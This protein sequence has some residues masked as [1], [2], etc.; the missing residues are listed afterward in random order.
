MKVFVSSTY[1]DL[2]EHRKAV[3][4]AIQRLGYQPIGMEDFGSRP[5][6]WNKAALNAMGGCGA[7]VGIYAHRYGSIPDGDTLSITEQE[8]DKARALGIPCFCYRVDPDYSWPPKFVEHPAKDKLDALL[9]KVDSLLRSKFT[10]PDDLAKK[11]RQI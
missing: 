5:E 4:E 7:F 10:D 11:P 1:D 6:E 9:K 3:R 2:I 8:F